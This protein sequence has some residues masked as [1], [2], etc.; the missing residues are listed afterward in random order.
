MKEGLRLAFAGFFYQFSFKNLGIVEGSLQF[1]LFAVTLTFL[2]M[3]NRK[4]PGFE[5]R[6]PHVTLG[7]LAT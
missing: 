5:V 2:I 1:G 7:V 6:D 4:D 3:A